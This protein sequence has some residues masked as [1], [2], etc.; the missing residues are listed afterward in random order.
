VG[1]LL[2]QADLA[3]YQAK[4]AGRNTLRFFDPQ[5]QAVVTAR[6]A[7]EADLRV[8]LAQ[9]EFLL[10]YQP[11][12]RQADEHTG[13]V[14]GVEA[15]LRWKHPRRGMVPPSDFIPL[16]EETGLILPL[17]RWVLHHACKLLAD[18]QADPLRR[19]LTMAVNVSSSQFRSPSFVEDVARVLAITGAPSGQLK[20]ELTESVLV[21]DM[22]ATIA[23]MTALRAYGVGFSLDDFGT[24]YSSLSYLKRM[25]LDQLK[26]DQS[27]VR[28]LLTDPN[29]AAIVDTIIGL[30]RSLGLEVI[31]EGVETAEQRDLLAHAGCELY[32]GYFFSKALPAD[33]LDGF[34]H[35][36]LPAP[37]TPPEREARAA[38]ALQQR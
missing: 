35:R 22:E 33:E 14:A 8:A 7:L 9:D 17:G 37:S 21:E 12:M 16:A 4:T 10:H 28:D 5:M 26:I 3:M 34:L 27:F 38:D 20:L 6:A 32:Q 31:A 1:E 11:Q 13:R 23:T 30:S 15:L 29:D 18:W 2:K 36:M 19:D 25:P 24:G